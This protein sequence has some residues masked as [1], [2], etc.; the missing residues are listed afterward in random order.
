MNID[1]SKS[2]LFEL[3]AEDTT[4]EENMSSLDLSSLDLDVRLIKKAKKMFF[5][6]EFFK[7]NYRIIIYYYRMIWK[8]LKLNQSA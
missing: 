5:K 8:T 2:E 7:K 6:I 4:N 3:S 1:L